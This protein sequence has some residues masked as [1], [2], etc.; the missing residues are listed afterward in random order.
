MKS[1]NIYLCFF[2]TFLFGGTHCHI[3]KKNCFSI[4]L[5]GWSKGS[6]RDAPPPPP[7]QSK[8]FQFHAVFSKNYCKIIGWCISLQ[9]WSL[10]SGNTLSATVSYRFKTVTS[11]LIAYLESGWD[12]ARNIKSNSFYL[13]MTYHTVADPEWGDQDNKLFDTLGG[14]EHI[15]TSPGYTKAMFTQY[16]GGIWLFTAIAASSIRIQ[17]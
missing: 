11:R 7:A 9:S 2:A 17:T 15:P 1:S 8:F 5:I 6:A 10:P 12:E 4:Y 16:R 3:V 13:F 14:G